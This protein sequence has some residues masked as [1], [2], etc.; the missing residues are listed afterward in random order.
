MKKLLLFI[1][2]ATFTFT[3]QSQTLMIDGANYSVDTLENHQVG[4]GT[5]YVSLRLLGPNRLDVFFLKTDLKNPYIQIR[6]AL[7]QDSIY[8]GERPSA[9][10]KRKSTE[11]AFYFA[12]T[13][14]DFYNTTGYVGYPI[15]GSMVESEVAKTPIDWNAFIIDDMNIPEIGKISYSGNIKTAT[16]ELAI[17]SFNHLRGENQLVLYNRHNGK[18]TRTNIYGTEVLVELSEGVAWATNRPLKAKVLKVEKNVGNM[19][20]PKGQAVMSGNGNASIFLD[21]LSVNEEIEININFSV[22]NNSTSNFTQMTGGDSWAQMLK[23]G[24]VEQGHVWNERHPRTGLGYSQQRD[25]LIFC[26]VDGRGLSVG[27]TTK[28]LAELMKSAGAYNA[29]NMDGGG[30]T[31][32]YVAEY[33]G[34]VNKTSDPG[35]ERAVSNSIFVV[36]TAPTDNNVTT[37][38]PY[39]SNY[40]LPYLGE[41]V[42]KFYGY[43]QYDVLLHP[44]LQNVVLT[45][46]PSLGKIDGN[47]FIAIGNTPGKITATYNGNIVTTINIDFLPVSGIKIRLDSI[48]TDNRKPYPIEVLATTSAGDALISAAAFTWEV[49]DPTICVVENGVVKALKNG[50]TMLTGKINDVS[51]QIKVIVEIPSAPVIVGDSLKT[52]EW[53]LSAPTFLNAKLN[54]EN[55]PQNWTTGSVINFVFAAG[56]APFLKLTNPVVFYG[57]PDTVKMVMNSGEVAISRAIFTLKSNQQ[58]T[59]TT[60]FNPTIHSDDYSLDIPV[61]KLFNVTDRANYPISFDNV[62]FYIDPSKMT[63][64]KAYSLAIKEISLVYKDFIITHLSSNRTDLLQVF[65]NPVEDNGSLTVNLSPEIS[66]KELRINMYNMNGQLVYSQNFGKTASSTLSVPINQTSGTYILEIKHGNESEKVKIVV[67]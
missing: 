9:V 15:G 42:P 26:V 64:T 2:V 50:T 52:S 57:L 18:R 48:L 63:T 11:G 44:D 23:D 1:L 55:L 16:D 34:P 32:M 45:C 59:A 33:G 21:K 49:E 38:K 20:I 40:K 14:G 56:R 39:E 65:P 30:S 28:Q 19:P 37:I 12:G 61:D 54:T 31:S 47:K 60:E 13:N 27:T 6:T 36:S 25:S 67:R 51:D 24:I 66:N 29:F 22:N 4:P 41:Y 62:N 53:N 3:L 43:N 7:G 5:Q 58:Q 17:N 10:A 46:P 35:G 8:S